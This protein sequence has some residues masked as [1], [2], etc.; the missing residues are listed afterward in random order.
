MD[1]SN[2]VGFC[3]PPKHSRFKPGQSGNPKG[4]KKGSKNTDVLFEEISNKKIIV[5]EGGKR[6][7]KTIK[8]GIIHKAHL[9]ALKGDNKARDT[10][11]KRL[12]KIENKKEERSKMPRVIIYGEDKILD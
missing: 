3:R 6:V 5:I 8:E 4:R 2:E 10:V 9:D 12:E 7:K 1:E 11:L